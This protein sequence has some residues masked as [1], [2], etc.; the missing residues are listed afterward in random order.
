MAVMREVL[1]DGQI[2]MELLRYK[3]LELFVDTRDA[4]GVAVR[5]NDEWTQFFSMNVKEL[6]RVSVL[7]ASRVVSLTIAVAQHLSRTGKLIQ[8]YSDPEMFDGRV[9]AALTG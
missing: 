2:R 5:V 3:P 9:A 4:T 7:V 8:I 1:A 6:T